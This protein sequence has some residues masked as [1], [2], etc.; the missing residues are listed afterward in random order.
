[1]I[2]VVVYGVAMK[3]YP[4]R[5]YH[6]TP[7]WVDDR[8]V[9]HVR[10]RTSKEFESSLIEPVVSYPILESIDVYR[11]VG[12]W[13]CC[14]LVLL[15]DH[16]HGLFSFPFGVGMSQVVAAWKKYH[17]LQNR[18]KW[19]ENFFDHRVRNAEEYRR[20]YSYVENNPVALGLC[21]YGKNW[22]YRTAAFDPV[23][24]PHFS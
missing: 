9:F 11:R 3:L 2:N 1:M 10:I 17:A 21:E 20:I 5:L 16:L 15:P 6:K 23:S 13:F 7:S 24:V 8:A 12:K 22:P 19:Q 14:L 18:I 4:R